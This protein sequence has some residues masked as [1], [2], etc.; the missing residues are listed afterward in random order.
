MELLPKI[1]N[2]VNL[3]R[4]SFLKVLLS[5]EVNLTLHFIFPDKLIEY[6]YNFMQLLNNLFKVG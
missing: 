5:R 1:V 3:I 6:Q 2:S 4:L